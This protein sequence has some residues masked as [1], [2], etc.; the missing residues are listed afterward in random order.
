MCYQRQVQGSVALHMKGVVGLLI[1]KLRKVYCWVCKRKEIK[2]GEYLAKLQAITWLSCA[3]SSFL[4]VCWPGT[5]SPWDSHALASVVPRFWPTLYIKVSLTVSSV[6]RLRIHDYMTGFAQKLYSFAFC[7]F[8]FIFVVCYW[9][10]YLLFSTF[11]GTEWPVNKNM[12][13]APLRN[14]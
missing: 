1:T 7:I 10:S 3:L 12:L 6:V 2:I 8:L 9:M 13:K 5:Q 4:A 14:D 11:Y